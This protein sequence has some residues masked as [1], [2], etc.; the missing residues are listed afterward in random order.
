MLTLKIS[1]QRKLRFV[2]RQIIIMMTGII[3]MLTGIRFLQTYIRIVKR[4]PLLYADLH[5]GNDDSYL[6]YVKHA[7][8]YAYMVKCCAEG[9]FCCGI[10]DYFLDLIFGGD[11]FL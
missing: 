2:K 3:V 1:V 4:L 8:F 11:C 10:W 9:G 6:I 7:R 5:N